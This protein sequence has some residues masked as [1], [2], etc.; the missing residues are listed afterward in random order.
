MDRFYALFLA[1][2]VLGKIHARTRLRK[3]VF[4]V[5]FS[6]PSFEGVVF[7]RVARFSPLL[8]RQHYK[9]PIRSGKCRQLVLCA[10]YSD[11]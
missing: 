11:T 1:L 8:K 3:R 6:D 7:L 4:S 9:F 5:V 10:K 2:A